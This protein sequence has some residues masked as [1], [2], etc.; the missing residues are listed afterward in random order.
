MIIP[1]IIIKGVRVEVP[2]VIVPVHVHGNHFVFCIISITADLSI[3]AK[4][5]AVYYLKY[6]IPQ[7][8]TPTVYDF[9]IELKLLYLFKKIPE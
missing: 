5:R 8:R 2:L 3:G 7:Y 4:N 6:I 9:K 1:R